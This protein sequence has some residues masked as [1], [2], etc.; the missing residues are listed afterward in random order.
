MF[1][2]IVLCSVV[3]KEEWIR[4]DEDSKGFL[5]ESEM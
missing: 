3:D 1:R 5:L 2:Y 4:L